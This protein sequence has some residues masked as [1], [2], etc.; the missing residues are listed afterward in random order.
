M[1]RTHSGTILKSND[2]R[3]FNPIGNPTISSLP[4]ISFHQNSPDAPPPGEIKGEFEQGQSNMYSHHGS[5]YHRHDFEHGIQTIYPILPGMMH[6]QVHPTPFTSGAN[7]NAYFTPPHA[8]HIDGVPTHSPGLLTEALGEPNPSY[9][10][11]REY[12]MMESYPQWSSPDGLPIQKTSKRRKSSATQP[13]QL[14]DDDRY[15]MKLK[16]EDQLPWKEIVNRFKEEGR[17]SHRVPALQMR[18]KRIK[19]R[20]RQWTPED[21][22]HHHQFFIPNTRCYPVRQPLQLE[23]LLDDAKKWLDKHYWEIVASKMMEYGRK[24]KIP[25]TSCEK[26]W[27]EL[28]AR[29][30]SER[31]SKSGSG[32]SLHDD[33]P[34]SQSHSLATSPVTNFSSY[35]EEDGE[36]S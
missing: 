8:H 26:K 29:R 31:D 25:G 21:V 13:W 14:S 32:R 17:G 12:N 20:I 35:E 11:K 18:L 2:R 4:Q 15:L 33:L 9:S 30:E 22:N 16:D 27:K 19:E 6:T 5:P 34:H 10:R 3:L 7:P 36:I 28:N 23:K 24:E 1:N